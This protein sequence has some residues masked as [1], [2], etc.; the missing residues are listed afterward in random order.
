[1][2]GSIQGRGIQLV[3]LWVGITSTI[4]SN[5]AGTGRWSHWWMKNPRRFPIAPAELRLVWV[6]KRRSTIFPSHG[7]Q[8]QPWGW[9]WCYPLIVA[10]WVSTIV[11]CFF[12][13]SASHGFWGDW[14]F[15]TAQIYGTASQ[16][17]L[18]AG[19]L[20]VRWDVCFGISTA[21]EFLRTQ[22]TY[23]VVLFEKTHFTRMRTQHNLY[24][25][26]WNL[27]SK[28]SSTAKESTLL[29]DVSKWHWTS[30]A[31]SPAPRYSRY[32]P[33]HVRTEPTIRKTNRRIRL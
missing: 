19:K 4:T 31:Y 17:L 13:R 7:L 10:L 18:S 24:S 3:S 8:K 30:G 12:I 20:P 29:S 16:T 14:S 1:M 15:L 27:Q 22:S 9:I 23:V 5:A 21:V 28:D 26:S 6:R 25:M 11:D 2:Q 32:R 33:L